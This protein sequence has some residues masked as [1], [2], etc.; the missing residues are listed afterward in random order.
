[1]HAS[2][3]S[4]DVGL[5]LSMHLLYLILVARFRSFIDPAIIL[6]ASPPGIIGVLATLA[7]RVGMR[8]AS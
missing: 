3:R 8:E 7:E 2:F 5:I 4:F 1:M 6:L